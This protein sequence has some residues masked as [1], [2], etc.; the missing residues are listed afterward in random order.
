RHAFVLQG[1]PAL[2]QGDGSEL[3][4]STHLTITPATA[5][6][7]D[8]LIAALAAGAEEARG[9]AP[10]L[11]DEIPDPEALAAAAR[12]TGDV[13]MTAVLALIERLPREATAAMLS[14]FL[15][16]FTRPR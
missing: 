3:P 6:V 14:E 15:A 7:I 10:A 13:D 8:D 11:P 2:V 5:S 4:R 16:A 1:Q 12:E 9:T